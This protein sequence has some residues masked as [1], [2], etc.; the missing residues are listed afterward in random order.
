M[1]GTRQI[2]G[3]EFSAEILTNGNWPID[4]K[5]PCAIPMSMKNCIS[6]FEQFYKNKY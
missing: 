5:P 6:R 4:N 2:D 3:I 1:P